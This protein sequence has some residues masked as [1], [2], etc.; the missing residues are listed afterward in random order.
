M[1][2]FWPEIM[3]VIKFALAILRENHAVKDLQRE[4]K[5]NLYQALKRARTEARIKHEKAKSKGP[6]F[7]AEDTNAMLSSG[8]DLFFDDNDTVVSRGED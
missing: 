2:K 8:S 6:E 7:M 1:G 3:L 4:H 5:L